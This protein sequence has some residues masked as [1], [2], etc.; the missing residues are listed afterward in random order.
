MDEVFSADLKLRKGWFCITCFIDNPS[1][2]EYFIK[3]IGRER[4]N[5]C[6]K[7]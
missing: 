3:A 6:G 5:D 4:K 1:I 2:N 7:S